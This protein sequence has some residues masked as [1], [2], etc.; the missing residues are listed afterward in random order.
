MTTYHP[1][2]NL[3]QA[4]IVSARLVRVLSSTPTSLC[5]WH[6][7]HANH[8]SDHDYKSHLTNQQPAWLSARDTVN[9]PFGGRCAANSSTHASTQIERSTSDKTLQIKGN[10]QLRA[11][12]FHA[13]RKLIA[14]LNTHGNQVCKPSNSMFTCKGVTM[15]RA[16]HRRKTCAFLV[17]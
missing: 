15:R 2:H 10:I 6:I 7:R 11:T 4:N 1:K 9:P 14:I 13:I 3:R 17:A 16:A 5:A 12:S 8:L